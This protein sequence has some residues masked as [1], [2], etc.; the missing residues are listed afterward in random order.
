MRSLPEQQALARPARGGVGRAATRAAWPAA[1]MALAWG[2]GG[3]EARPEP[4]QPGATAAAPMALRRALAMDRIGDVGSGPTRVLALDVSAEGDGLRALEGTRLSPVAAGGPWDP[5]LTG[6]VVLEGDGAALGLE[7]ALDAR[8]VDFDAVRVRV[9]ALERTQVAVALVRGDTVVALSERAVLENPGKG[10]YGRFDFTAVPQPEQPL[11]AIRVLFAAK[12]AVG[13][14]VGPCAVS[15]LDLDQNPLLWSLPAP[16]ET[17]RVTCAG[18][19]L[20]GVAISGE[21]HGRIRIPEPLQGLEGA[22]LVVSLGIPERLQPFDRRARAELRAGGEVLLAQDL[23]LGVWQEL[24]AP[25]PAASEVTV[26]LL[27]SQPD[28][29]VAVLGNARAVRGQGSG[30]TVLLITSDTHRYDHLSCSPG[31]AEVATPG[32]DALAARGTRFDD[33]WSTTN[34]TTPS[35]VALLTGLHPAE[36]AVIDN[37][38]GITAEV[39]SLAEVFSSAGFET[40]AFVSVPH[41]RDEV[42]GLSQGFERFYEARTHDLDLAE[43]LPALEATLARTAGRDRFLWLHLF[44]AH[45]PYAPPP[46]FLPPGEAPAEE[47]PL[48]EWARPTWEPETDSAWDLARRYRGE[49]EYLDEALARVLAHPSLQDA[50][51]AFTADHGE[52]LG[53]HGIWFDH[54]GL[55]P[56]TLHVP[57]ILAGPGVPAGASVSRSVQ[58]SWLAHTLALLVLGDAA[59]LP[60][61]DLLGEAPAETR[62]ALAS[63]ATQACIEE[64]GDLLILDLVGAPERRGLPTRPLHGHRLFHLDRDPRCAVDVARVEPLRAL[65]LR[66]KLIAWLRSS[67]KPGLVRLASLSEADEAQLAA[68]GYGSGAAGEGEP[69]RE[70]FPATCDCPECARLR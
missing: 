62:F 19:S 2:C 21:V 31:A 29:R 25:M 49:V 68:L 1:L 17:P 38:M 18:A 34:V 22:Q 36:S 50:T 32:L 7:L 66:R 5:T 23:E 61:A 57:L 35:H 26:H 65:K 67:A 13:T 47:E 59:G 63:G 44:D 52:S 3:Q 9:G 8:P 64:D 33:C 20:E 41:L 39:T 28:R 60:G 4:A 15:D 48:P 43:R 24:S 30:R 56:D 42:S 46:E 69:V 37:R 55:Y 54:Q 53:G 12:S 11:D 10:A 58:Q 14:A 40:A 70:W 27:G 45:A 51:V 6:G 16:E